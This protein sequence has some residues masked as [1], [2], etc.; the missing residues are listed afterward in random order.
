MEGC[1]HVGLAWLAVFAAGMGISACS[2]GKS[3]DTTASVQGNWSGSYTASGTTSSIPIFALIQQGGSAYLFDS[4]GVVY[5]LPAFSGSVKDSGPVTAYPA[6]GYTFAD[7]S[8]SMHLNMQAATSSGQM[9]MGLDADGDSDQAAS[10]QAHLLQLETWYGVPSVAGGQWMGYYLSPTPT[11]LALTVA[12]DGSFTG[13]DAYGCQLK[14]GL[15]QLAADASLFTLSIQSSGSSPA[16]G[17]TMTGLVHE[18][19]YDSF[20]LFNGAS[21]TYYYFCASDSKSAFVAELKVQ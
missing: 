8:T 11:G 16:C 20:D 7:G 6:K 1:R 12:T 9:D 19:A 17:G 4:T 5:A 13:T 10:G 15:T 2:G 18:S 21:G 14:G 3:D